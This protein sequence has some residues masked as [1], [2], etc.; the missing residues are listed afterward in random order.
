M[1]GFEHSKT[2]FFWDMTLDPRWIGAIVHIYNILLLPVFSPYFW[3]RLQ[4]RV[5]LTAGC[6][7][8]AR[9]TVQLYPLSCKSFRP[10]SWN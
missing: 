6:T 4:Y 8:F 10:Y 9:K 7:N 1:Y 2:I 3:P 5:T